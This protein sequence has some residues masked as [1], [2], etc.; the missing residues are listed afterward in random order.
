MWPLQAPDIR[1]RGLFYLQQRKTTVGASLLAMDVNDN[2]GCLDQSIAWAFFASKL[3]PT[4]A[5]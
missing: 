4:G 1:V 5:V 3:A 2:A